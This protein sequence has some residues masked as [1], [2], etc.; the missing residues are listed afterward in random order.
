M[1]LDLYLHRV[2]LVKSRTM[3]KEACDRGK[4]TVDGQEAKG[5]HAVRAGERV[6]C[7]LGTRVLEIEVLAVPEGQVSRK[8][9][10]SYYRV[11]SD[12][13]VTLEF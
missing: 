13:R 12:E 7:D 4:V 9:A 3:A 8:D 1:R 10:P 2:C 11:L 5:S 6:R